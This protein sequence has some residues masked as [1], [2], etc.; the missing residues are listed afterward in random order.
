[1]AGHLFGGGGEIHRRGLGRSLWSRICAFVRF[2][3]AVILYNI[4]SQYRPNIVTITVQIFVATSKGP[5][6]PR[7]EYRLP[8]V[9]NTKKTASA[10]QAAVCCLSSWLAINKLN[11]ENDLLLVFQKRRFCLDNG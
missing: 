2:I 8:V 5:T 7:A 1:V 11:I 3:L 6:L 9:Y 4:H 10:S